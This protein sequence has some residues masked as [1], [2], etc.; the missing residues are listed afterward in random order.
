MPIE[1]RELIIKAKMKDETSVD[2]DNAGGTEE[3]LANQQELLELYK[4]QIIKE[5]LAKVAIL[6]KKQRDR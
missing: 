2:S 5:C 1:V 3:A 4:S 6:L